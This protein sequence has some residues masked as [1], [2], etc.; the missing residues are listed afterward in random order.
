ML[1][2][3]KSIKIFKELFKQILYIKKLDLIK[4]NK[5]MQKKMCI[6]ILDYKSSSKTYIIYESKGKGKEYIINNDKLIYEGEYINGE[7]N[8]KGKE[9]YDDNKIKFEGKYLYGKRWNGKGYDIENNMI[10][11]IKDGKGLIKEYNNEGLLVFEGEYINGERNGKGKEY[12]QYNILKFEGEYLYGKR[13]NGKGYD[14]RKNIV[15]ELKDGKGYIKEYNGYT[16]KLVFEG[17]YLY[18]D[19]NGKAKEYYIYDGKL[20]FEGEYLNGKRNGNGKLYDCRDM[21]EFEGEYFNGYKKKGKAYIAEKLEFDGEY[22]L[23]IKS[24]GKGYDG[25]G[26]VVYEIINGNGKIIE[27]DENRMIKFEGDY[28]NNEKNGNGKEYEFGDL[29]FEGEYKNGKRNGKG[30]EFD[31]NRNIIF[32]GEYENGRRIE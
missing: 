3:I 11:E 5:E 1:K 7:R 29:I 30:K 8:G 23:N 17:E 10:Y 25:K 24:N 32:E 18:G 22:I 21:L 26:N 28:I 2:C 15:Y 12:Y 4:Y 16:G 9:Y 31:L 27:Y 6:N 14:T 13:W 20:K 19:K